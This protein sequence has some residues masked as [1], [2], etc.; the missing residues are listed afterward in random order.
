MAKTVWLFIIMTK[1]PSKNNFS[2]L[3]KGFHCIKFK[4][5]NS[6]SKHCSLKIKPLKNNVLQYYFNCI[7]SHFLIYYFI[8]TKRQILRKSWA[9]GNTAIP[10]GNRTT[11]VKVRWLVSHCAVGRHHECTGRYHRNW[12]QCA[13]CAGF[14]C[15]WK[16]CPWLHYRRSALGFAP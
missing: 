16:Q 12:E 14:S 8:L 4:I 9:F 10:R 11:S 15:Q 1:K 5:I 3:I 13:W 2:G 7:S 6:S